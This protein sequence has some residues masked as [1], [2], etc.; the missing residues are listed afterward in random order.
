MEY[1]PVV[2]AG[3]R[4]FKI[5][6]S[7]LLFW[8]S[9]SQNEVYLV[10]PFLD[11]DILEEFLDI[12]L[13]KEETAN[14]GFVFVREKC[15]KSLTFKKIWAST[16]GNY[17]TREKKV[18]GKTV[19][20]KVWEVKTEISYFHAKFI[21]CVN[22]E[23]REAE[24]LLTSANFTKDHFKKYS[25]GKQNNESLS[26]HKMETAEFRKRFIEPMKEIY[27]ENME[28]KADPAPAHRARAPR[29][30]LKDLFLKFRNG[31]D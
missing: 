19:L 12:V 23:T 21:G 3:P 17:S 9:S 25:G 24:V 29:L 5:W 27:K 13:K 2:E 28:V 1:L 26:Y 18:L 6:K 22:T 11:E 4:V 30:D 20:S 10:S 7:T 31:I 15:Y 16:I 8:L 14:I